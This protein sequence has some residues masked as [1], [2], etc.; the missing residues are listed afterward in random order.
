[1]SGEAEVTH[2]ST[3]TESLS[4]GAKTF[5]G[6]QNSKA[7]RIVLRS[8]DYNSGTEFILLSLPACDEFS[9]GARNM[10]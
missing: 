6:R 4:N 3:V 2:P 8:S 10:H 7:I 1:M 5:W 9:D